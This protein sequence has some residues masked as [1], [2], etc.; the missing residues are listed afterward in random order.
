M[1]AGPDGLAF[2]DEGPDGNDEAMAAVVSTV[3]SVAQFATS[4]GSLGTFVSTNV[5]GANGCLVVYGIDQ[6]HLLAVVTDPTVNTVLLDRL[7]SRLVDELATVESN[8][9]TRPRAPQHL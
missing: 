3:L 4:T 9:I 7:A 1:I 2:E 5:R 8:G 6:S